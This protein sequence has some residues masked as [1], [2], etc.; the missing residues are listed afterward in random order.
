MAI[1]AGLTIVPVEKAVAV[2]ESIPPVLT[3]LTIELLLKLA[4]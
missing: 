4:T 2:L 1:P 3:N